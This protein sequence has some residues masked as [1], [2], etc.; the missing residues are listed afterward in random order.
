MKIGVEK[1]V[2]R[3]MLDDI[4]IEKDNFETMIREELFHGMASELKNKFDDQVTKENYRG[5]EGTRYILKMNYETERQRVIKKQK[6]QS[7][8]EHNA[9]ITKEFKDQIYSL[10]FEEARPNEKIKTY[11]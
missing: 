10:F 3:E 8:L 9:L 4:V 6:L 5:G 2:S 7:I 11:I 1:I